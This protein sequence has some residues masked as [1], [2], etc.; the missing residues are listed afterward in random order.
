MLKQFHLNRLLKES[1]VQDM[2]KHEQQNEN[3][4]LY[5]VCSLNQLFFWGFCVYLSC[6]SVNFDL[7]SIES[8][9]QKESQKINWV[10]YFSSSSCHAASTDLPDPLLHS[11]SIIH[12]SREVCQATS[13]IGTELLHI[14]SNWLFNL[15]LSMWRG[16]LE[17]IAYEFVF[18]SPAV[19]CMS[20]SSNLNSFLDGL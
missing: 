11:I 20:G 4:G 13:C 5:K 19:S 16:P 17:Y 7:R 14:G 1:Y 10:H 18:T 15:C 6:F 12:C 3:W 8:S 2:S 9:K